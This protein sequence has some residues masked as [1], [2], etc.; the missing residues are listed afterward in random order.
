M[1]RRIHTATYPTHCIWYDTET[2]PEK[3]DDHEE[4]HRLVFGWAAYCRYLGNDWWS[5][6]KWHR[7]T[8][9]TAFW[10]WVESK[11]QKKTSLWVYAHNAAYDA[12]VTECWTLLPQRGWLLS[13]AVID[14]PP[15]IV[16]WRRNK[17]TLRMLDTLNLWLVPLKVIGEVVGLLKLE[18]PK[19]WTN[20][21]DDDRYC[22]RDVEIIMKACIEWWAWLKRE[23][24]GGNAATIASQAFTAF[25]YRFLTHAILIDNNPSA[26]QLS[27]DAYHGGRVE[28]FKIGETHGPLYFL[29]VRSEYPTVM[30]DEEYPTVLR[31][32]YGGLDPTALAELLDRYAVVAHV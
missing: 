12:T 17:S 7:F 14:A 10:D 26:L 28:V 8:T 15:F 5:R 16:Y 30:R 23:G 9:A 27:R 25:R 4:R 21:R 32:V 22:K 3:V 13:N 19:E 31:G 18:A 11:V 1:L 29:D 24:L 6:P 2:K 20:S